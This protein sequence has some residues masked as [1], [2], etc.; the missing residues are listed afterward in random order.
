MTR[1]NELG[2]CSNTRSARSLKRD[3][4]KIINKNSSSQEV[5]ESNKEEEDEESKKSPF[6]GTPVSNKRE[7][8]PSPYA[9]VEDLLEALEIWDKEIQIRRY[10][11]TNVF[12][13]S[14]RATKLKDFLESF[15][16]NDLE[17]W[18]NYC[19]KISET[20]FLMGQGSNGWKVSLDWALEHSNAY[21]VLEDRYFLK[22]SESQTPEEKMSERIEE[23]QLQKE[24]ASICR[25]LTEDSSWLEISLE[26][27]KTI[28][29]S[30]YKSWFMELEVVHFSPSTL[31]LGVPSLFKRDVLEREFQESLLKAAKKVCPDLERV[32]VEVGE[33]TSESQE[34]DSNL[35]N[36]S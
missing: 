4:N 6:E 3:Y 33:G 30:A 7:G 26:L 16:G 9:K 35:K 23:A 11:E 13:T 25:G 28:G 21:K 27:I 20:P 29:F 36:P 34:S 31:R 18:R 12:M 15:F 5:S 17:K 24:V 2:A 14:T 22:P 10:P 8:E 32:V 1:S 19:R